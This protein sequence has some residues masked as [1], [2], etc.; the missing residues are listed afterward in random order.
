MRVELRSTD[1]RA[2]HGSAIVARRRAGNARCR[3][4]RPANCE[5]G[6]DAFGTAGEQTLAGNAESWATRP[7]LRSTR[8]SA[9]FEAARD[10]AAPAQA[11]YTLGHLQY[12]TRD[13]GVAAIRAAE[14]ATDA[15][16]CVD[17]KVGM[18]NSATLRAAS[19]LE[20]AAGMNASTQRAE[21]RALYDGA[22]R[23]LAEA[24]EYFGSH[25]MPVNAEYAVNMRGVRAV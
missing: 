13:D 11:Q 9:H 4:K 2:K 3:P 15:Y 8:R 24:A 6:Y 12:L 22:D 18:H 7:R 19:E 23:R 21:Q 5:L 1:H 17:D 16:E 20:I 25:D 10:D 14:A